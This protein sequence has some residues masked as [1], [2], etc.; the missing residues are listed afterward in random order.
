[1]KP[2][3]IA[4]LAIAAFTIFTQSAFAGNRKSFRVQ[5]QSSDV[6]IRFCVS[7]SDETNLHCI[8]DWIPVAPQR[9]LDVWVETPTKSCLIDY[10]ADFDY[11]QSV[12]QHNINICKHPLILLTD[13]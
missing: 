8:K 10:R 3:K 6:I 5:N 9:Y 2:L 12:E 4:A 1:M 13:G 7:G 11:G